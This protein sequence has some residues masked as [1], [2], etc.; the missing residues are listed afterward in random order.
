MLAVPEIV[1]GDA[2]VVAPSGRVDTTSCDVA[3]AARATVPE[4]KPGLLLLPAGINTP[5]PMASPVML[6]PDVSVALPPA[7]TI[8]A[9]LMV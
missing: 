7:L 2:A 6:N 1:S 5:W 9:A 3:M 8:R 4:P